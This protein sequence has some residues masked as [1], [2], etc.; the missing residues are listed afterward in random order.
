MLLQPRRV[1]REL[2]LGADA[3][4]LVEEHPVTAAQQRLY[5]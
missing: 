1:E 5:R 4:E 2:I 3:I